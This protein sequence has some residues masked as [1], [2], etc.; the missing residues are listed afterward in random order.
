MEYPF[1]VSKNCGW[2]PEGK[3]REKAKEFAM[4][5]EHK[6]G[7]DPKK[8]ERDP[9]GSGPGLVKPPPSKDLKRME[10]LFDPGEIA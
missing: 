3:L 1:L 2:K 10:I 7:V 8:T 4:Y 5:Y 9:K 6:H